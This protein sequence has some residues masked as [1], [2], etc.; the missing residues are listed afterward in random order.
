MNLNILHVLIQ[1]LNTYLKI[2]DNLD[3]N[4]I[5]KSSIEL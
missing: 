4:I 1:V 5:F 2:L 3:Y